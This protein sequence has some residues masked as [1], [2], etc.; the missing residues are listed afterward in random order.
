MNIKTIMENI[1]ELA[2]ENMTEDGI[3]HDDWPDREHD[4]VEYVMDELL[5]NFEIEK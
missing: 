5:E 3:H 1:V 2:S 4:F